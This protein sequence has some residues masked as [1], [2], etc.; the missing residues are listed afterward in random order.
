MRNIRVVDFTPKEIKL[1]NV[2]DKT[3]FRR[4]EDGKEL[5]LIAFY[6]KS[7]RAERSAKKLPASCAKSFIAGSEHK[8]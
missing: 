5:A 8:R 2:H 1:F 7:G 3:P 4:A 6:C